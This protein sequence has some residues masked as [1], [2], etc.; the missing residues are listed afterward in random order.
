MLAAGAVLL[1]GLLLASDTARWWSWIAGAGMLAYAALEY[2]RSRAAEH[3]PVAEFT[4]T[5]F[6]WREPDKTLFQSV[7]LADL[8]SAEWSTNRAVLFERAGT[9]KTVPLK[10]LDFREGSFAVNAVRAELER[11]IQANWAASEADAHSTARR[12]G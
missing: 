4:E 3:R 2:V 9:F 11:V 5:E 10:R 12:P 6:R 7:R 8:V 1:Y